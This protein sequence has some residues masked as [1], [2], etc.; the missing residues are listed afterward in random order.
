VI[1]VAVL[2]LGG[3][4][5]DPTDP[6][7]RLLFN[8]LAM[9]AEFES[10][11]IVC[12]P[13]RASRSHEQ[14]E[15]SAVAS[16]SSLRARRHISSNSIGRARRTLPSSL[17]SSAL[18]VRRSIARSN[19]PAS[20][21]HRSSGRHR[22]EAAGLPVH[23]TDRGSRP[24]FAAGDSY[25][26][27]GAFTASSGPT[28]RWASTRMAAR[29]RERKPGAL[30]GRRGSGPAEAHRRLSQPRERALRARSRRSDGSTT[31]RVR[32]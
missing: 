4:V 22:A 20:R 19:A 25:P 24:S 17:S 21:L 1:A 14:P 3:S 15:N 8:V 28:A 23:D 9:V 5:H 30:A 31:R 7:G 29:P 12:A 10:D 6:V 16:R 11:L 13:G 26:K 27:R 18:D 32:G 2:N